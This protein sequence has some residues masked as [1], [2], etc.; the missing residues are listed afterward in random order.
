MYFR[1][2]DST[3]AI[4]RGFLH[5]VRAGRLKLEN[6]DFD[7][8]NITAWG[9]YPLGDKSY[10]KL[11]DRIAKQHFSAATP[12][13]RQN[14]LTFYSAPAS[15]IYRQHDGTRVLHNLDELKTADLSSPL[16]AS[17]ALFH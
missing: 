11:L 14:I 6:R 5:Q 1:S 9:E 15:S 8:G 12:A 3:V 10:A 2:V 7:T 17:T 13:L 16:S 4:Y